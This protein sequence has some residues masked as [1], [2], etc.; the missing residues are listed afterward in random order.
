FIGDANRRIAED[1]LRVFRFF[2][3]TASHGNERFDEDGL[4]AV[5]KAASDLGHVSSE[6]VGAEMRRMI[7]LPRIAR[8]LETMTETGVLDLPRDLLER[9]GTYERRAHK[10]N[11]TARL[12]I[13]VQSLGTRILKKRWRLSN[14]EIGTAES[15][16]LG[17]KLIT[18]FHINEAAY[19]FPAHLSDAVDVAATFAGWTEAG[20]AAIVEHLSTIEVPTF[21]LSGNDLIERGMRPG[22]KIGAELDRLE[23]KWIKSGFKLDRTSLLASV[24]R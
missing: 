21:P 22:P 16:L 11:A 5:H 18:D 4:V 12:A 1:K 6:R 23:Q 10:P 8:T 20:K 19:R 7:A 9:L 17:A 24:Q 2:R 13:L 15:I 14:D 3:F